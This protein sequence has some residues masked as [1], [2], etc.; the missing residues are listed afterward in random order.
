MGCGN[1]PTSPTSTPT[2]TQTFIPK[3]PTQTPI[4]TEIPL[5]EGKIYE[6]A[7]QLTETGYEVVWDKEDETKLVLEYTDPSTGKKSVVPELKFDKKGTWAR[8]YTFDTPYGTQEEVTIDSRVDKLKVIK[9]DEAVVE[10]PGGVRKLE[11]LDETII[12]ISFSGWRLQEGKWVREHEQGEV[13]YNAAE[14]QHIL[15]NDGSQDPRDGMGIMLEEDYNGNALWFSYRNAL[16]PGIARVNGVIKYNDLKDIIDT[17]RGEGWRATDIKTLDNSGNP[18]FID[19]TFYAN[20]YLL[21]GNSA[22]I[23]RDRNRKYQII[24]IDA[25]LWD[26]KNWSPYFT[27]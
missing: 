16:F 13:L 18:L 26:L 12:F 25:E 6:L 15:I 17:S 11:K 8:T 3:T 10:Y 4:P 22:I 2:A 19:T 5:P 21:S 20:L 14:A 7:L 27:K 23:Y 24:L 1:L 9:Q